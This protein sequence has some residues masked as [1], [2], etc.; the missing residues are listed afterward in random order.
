MTTFKADHDRLLGGLPG[1]SD[2]T[3]K[4]VRAVLTGFLLYHLTGDKDYKEFADPEGSLP[5]T[6][7]P[8]PEAPA[9]TA[10]DRIVA[11]FR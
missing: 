7:L 6:S 8:D 4:T 5:H 9:V 10:E 1:S 3:Q 2:K 11:L